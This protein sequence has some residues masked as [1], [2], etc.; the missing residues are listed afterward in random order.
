MNGHST[1]SCGA[2]SNRQLKYIIDKYLHLTVAGAV[3]EYAVDN[4]G[5][6]SP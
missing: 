3:E 6:F 5:R 1:S 2:L 4:E